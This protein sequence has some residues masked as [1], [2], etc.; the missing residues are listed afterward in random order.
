MQCNRIYI[1]ALLCD[2]LQIMGILE[3]PLLNQKKKKADLRSTTVIHSNKSEDQ[4]IR[5][6]AVKCD[7]NTATGML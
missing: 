1:T 6:S 3:R 5:H 2:Q 7:G 4:V